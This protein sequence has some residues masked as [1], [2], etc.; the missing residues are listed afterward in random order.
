MS[1]VH[2]QRNK[3]I[4]KF[5]KTRKIFKNASGKPVW[6]GWRELDSLHKRYPLHNS[7][8]YD[9]KSLDDRGKDRT[10]L[11]F[12]L[13]PKELKKINNFLEL[14]CYD[15][16]VSCNLARKGKKTTAIDNRIDGFDNRAVDEGVKFFQMNAENL[17]FKNEM[18]DFV[19]SFD[20]FEHFNKP[21]LVLQEA[22]RVVKSGGFIY[23][24][25]GPL[26]FSQLGLHIYNITGVPYCQFLFPKELLKEYFNTEGANPF[27]FE[28][29]QIVSDT[30]LNGWSLEEYRNLWKN[31]SHV[32]KK[33]KYKE[34]KDL[35]QFDIIRKYPSCFKSKVNHFESLTISFIEGLFRKK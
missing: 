22:I 14:G 17:E 16:M 8:G 23:L 6:L 19:F 33:I 18:F 5:S 27:S 3:K 24:N 15:G 7:Y 32:L 13:V 29:D 30:Q 34:S 12:S 21:D 10:E 25:F 26:F 9:T 31:N 11:I 28:K 35:S 1:V 4:A 20:A 2:N